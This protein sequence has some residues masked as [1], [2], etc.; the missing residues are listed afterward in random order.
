[1]EF[2][3]NYENPKKY[4]L[5][6]DEMAYLNPGA[7]IITYDELNK[8]DDINELFDKYDRI[9]ILYLLRS[10][11][12]GHWVCLFKNRAGEINYFDSYGYPL[13]HHLDNLTPYQ[14]AEY[15]EKQKR[16]KYLL[17]DYDVIDNNIILQGPNTKTCGM[18]TTYR[19][20][21]YQLPEK[22]FIDRM[23]DNGI[24]DPDQFVGEYCMKR[25]KNMPNDFKAEIR[26]Q[27]FLEGQL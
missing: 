21:N 15:D 20:H 19:L 1:M 13:D 17:K 23:I 24:T 8:I 25:L 26:D 16:L 12:D 27:S 22:H 14:R 10:K 11:T 3:Y 7:L 2:F 9:V 4:A 18:H 5:S 6:S